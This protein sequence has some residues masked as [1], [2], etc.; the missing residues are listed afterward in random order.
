MLNRHG[1]SEW[2]SPVSVIPRDSGEAIRA[3]SGMEEH[4][5]FNDTMLHLPIP[6]AANVARRVQV[7]HVGI[8]DEA[9][10]QQEAI[11]L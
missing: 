6:V 9:A 3:A 7:L 8:A 4:F 11:T 10:E 1:L 2:T 5:V